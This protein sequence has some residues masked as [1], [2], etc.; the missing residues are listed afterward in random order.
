[1][2]C[3]Y[4]KFNVKEK[5]RVLNYKSFDA[6]FP[7]YYKQ[8]NISNTLTYTDFGYVIGKHDSVNCEFV[9]CLRVEIIVIIHQYSNHI[10]PIYPNVQ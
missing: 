2:C 1:L 4:Y 3:F 10:N 6:S 5:A 7:I 8:E 9:G